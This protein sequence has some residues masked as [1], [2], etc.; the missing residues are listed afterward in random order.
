M[1]E[2]ERRLIAEV[3]RQEK[4]EITKESNFRREKL[5]K[6]FIVKILYKQ[7]NRK[8][9]KKNLKKLERNC[10]SCEQ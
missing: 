6:K 4:L 3:S 10:Q 2:F 7:N 1:I 8:F 9:E 5:Q